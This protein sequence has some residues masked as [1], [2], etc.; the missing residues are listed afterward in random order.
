MADVVGLLHND[1]IDHGNGVVLGLM[2]ILNHIENSIEI[3][4]M[5]GSKPND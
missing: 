1:Y 4:L 2:N 3:N 5:R